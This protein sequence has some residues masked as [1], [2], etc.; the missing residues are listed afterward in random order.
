MR[1]RRRLIETGDAN[2]PGGMFTRAGKL[3]QE[4]EQAMQ[5]KIP[6][7]SAIFLPSIFL[8]DQ[9]SPL[10]LLHQLCT[11][12]RKPDVQE[13][14]FAVSFHW[15]SSRMRQRIKR[16]SGF[17]GGDFGR[18]LQLRLLRH[19]KNR[20]AG[21]KR[22]SGKRMSGGA[23]AG[24]WGFGLTWLNGALAGNSLIPSLVGQSHVLKSGLRGSRVSSEER[25][26]SLHCDTGSAMRLFLFFYTGII[27]APGI[28]T[29]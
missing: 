4:N 14:L 13:N 16:D 17:C 27:A 12:S 10:T 28:T 11:Q 29:R 2:E 22:I 23:R 6:P 5:V 18:H 15:L 24:R 19:R 8:P 26:R 20:N 9:R 21:G 3:G 7:P 1:D 25:I